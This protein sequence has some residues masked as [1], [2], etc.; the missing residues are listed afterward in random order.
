MNGVNHHGLQLQYT[1][2]IENKL[3]SNSCHPSAFYT[4]HH[5]HVFCFALFMQNQVDCTSTACTGK[6]ML[7]TGGIYKGCELGN[8]GNLQWEQGVWQH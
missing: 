6:E 8:T 3:V 2:Q 1:T 5:P 4:L 7:K